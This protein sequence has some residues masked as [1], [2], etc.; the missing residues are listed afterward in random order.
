M[1]DFRVRSND[2]KSTNEVVPLGAYR[3]KFKFPAPDTPIVFSSNYWGS[4]GRR[5]C[6]IVNTKAKLL[7]EEQSNACYLRCGF[8]TYFIKVKS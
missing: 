6:F 7:P 4:Y 8:A 5:C 1:G 2:K 3:G